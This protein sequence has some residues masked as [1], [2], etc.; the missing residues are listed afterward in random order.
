MQERSLGTRGHRSFPA[1][2]FYRVWI[3]RKSVTSHVWAWAVEWNKN[4][5]LVGF[6]WNE[7]KIDP[8]FEA[9]PQLETTIHHQEGSRV[10][11]G[12][13]E[14]ALKEEDDTLF[15]VFEN[16]EPVESMQPLGH[17]VTDVKD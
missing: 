2:G 5:R 9:V 13:T 6:A 16:A 1:D 11:R 10:T 14:V 3:K 4:V 15:N 7:S 12:R 8:H 17:T